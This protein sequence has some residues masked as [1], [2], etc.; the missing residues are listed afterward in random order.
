[1]FV[2]HASPNN[3]IK[4]LFDNSYVTIFPHIAYN[5]GLFYKESGKPWTNDDLEIPYGFENKIYFKKG[6]K[7]KGKP[8]LY[9]LEV[10]PSNIIMHSNFP[11]E[12]IIKE[13]ISVKKIKETDV[14]NLLSK[15]I[16]LLRLVEEINFNQNI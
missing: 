14:K 1:M 7:P 13:G 4:K 9:K 12:F 6:K 2:Y 8:T 16:K 11:F 15:S 5:M 3:N 10:D